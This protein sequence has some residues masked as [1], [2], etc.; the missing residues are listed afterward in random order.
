MPR[1]LNQMK[2]WC[3]GR[4]TSREHL[5]TNRINRMSVLLICFSRFLDQDLTMGYNDLLLL[6][7]GATNI[8]ITE[9]MAESV[10]WQ[11]FILSSWRLET[12]L[13]L[14]L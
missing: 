1:T 6:P 5:W 10:I 11:Y 2:P 8:R 13:T 4:C 7:A 9:V 14:Q 3:K 12:V